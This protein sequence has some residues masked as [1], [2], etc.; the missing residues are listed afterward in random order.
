MIS[1][2][3]TV[4]V[5]CREGIIVY[6]VLIITQV[7]TASYQIVGLV[8]NIVGSEEIDIEIDN[9]YPKGQLNRTAVKRNNICQLFNNMLEPN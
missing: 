8:G 3:Q 2:S 7:I 4:L 1:N 9:Q 6:L 5:R